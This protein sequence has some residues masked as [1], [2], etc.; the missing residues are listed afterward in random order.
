MRH[1]IVA[2]GAL[3]VALTLLGWVVGRPPHPTSSP[4]VVAAAPAFVEPPAV[5]PSTV[6]PSTVPPSTVPPSTVPPSTVPDAMVPDAASVFLRAL[7]AERA[8]HGLAPLTRRADLDEM[9]RSWAARLAAEGELRHSDLIHEIVA[10]D[11]TTAGE[12][13][14]YGP[15]PTRVFEALVDSPAHRAN[16]L[17]PDFHAVG[18]GVVWVDDVVW[19]AHLFAGHAN[20]E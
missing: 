8:G 1:G 18:I 16:I 7:D 19:T 11:W 6:P 9:A 4:V 3:V 20:R 15:S 2:A 10:G 5:P 13:L 17:D 14:G 12:N